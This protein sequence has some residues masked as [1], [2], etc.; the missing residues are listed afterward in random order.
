MDTSKTEP[1]NTEEIQ[2]MQKTIKKSLAIS[3]WP[4]W[5]KFH[6]RGEILPEGQD[7]YLKITHY[8]LPPSPDRNNTQE[9][10]LML[11]FYHK[12]ILDRKVEMV[13]FELGEELR[14]LLCH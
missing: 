5:C 10:F 8:A 7:S 12:I 4:S 6:A 9:N 14:K 3:F 1:T 2:A 11:D 13:S